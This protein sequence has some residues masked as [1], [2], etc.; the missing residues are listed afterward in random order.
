MNNINATLG[1]LQN[2]GGPS[3]T[4]ALLP[5]S[6]AIDAGNPSGCTDGHGHLLK[7]DQR[8][9]PCHDAEDTGGREMGA[10]ESQ[11]G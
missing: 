2:N 4:Q 5:G 7:S 1:P 3:Q 9:R 6:P 11:N 10:Y 8:G